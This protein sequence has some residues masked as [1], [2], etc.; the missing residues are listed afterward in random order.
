MSI[1]RAPRLLLQGLGHGLLFGQ[2]E[3]CAGRTV[4]A[5]RGAWIRGD[6]L[7]VR[8][9]SRPRNRAL[10]AVLNEHFA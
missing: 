1:S 4:F 7:C 9:A 10:M 8:C 3:I 5:L 2:C 6:L